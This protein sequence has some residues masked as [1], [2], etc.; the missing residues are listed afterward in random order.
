MNINNPQFLD[1][2]GIAGFIFYAVY[3]FAEGNF[4]TQYFIV[5]YFIYA[6]QNFILVFA[7]E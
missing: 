2:K 3:P 1:I 5:K 6:R 7:S 4:V